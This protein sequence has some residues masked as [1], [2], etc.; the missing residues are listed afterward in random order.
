MRVPRPWIGALF[1]ISAVL[2]NVHKV[3]DRHCTTESPSCETRKSRK[4]KNA[5][6]PTWKKECKL[7]LAWLCLLLPGKMGTSYQSSPTLHGRGSDARGPKLYLSVCEISSLSQTIALYWLYETIR[8]S[9]ITYLSCFNCI[10]HVATLSLLSCGDI[11]HFRGCVKPFRRVQS[12]VIENDNGFSAV[13][14]CFLQVLSVYV[15]TEP[16][17]VRAT[18]NAALSQKNCFRNWEP[19]RSKRVLRHHDVVLWRITRGY[20]PYEVSPNCHI[21]ANISKTSKA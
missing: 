11:L 7:K 15:S 2:T 17:S 13:H 9:Q 14:N 19:Q 8:G 18:E 6:K 16:Y 1:Q 12:P 20:L 21:W 3:Q 10:A 5:P 4:C